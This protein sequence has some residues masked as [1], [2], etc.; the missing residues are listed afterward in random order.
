MSLSLLTG[1]NMSSINYTRLKTNLSL[2]I[3]RLKLLEKKKSEAAQRCRKEIADY[4]ENGKVERAKIRVEQI[5]R[6]DYLVEAMEIVEMFCDLLLARFGMIQQMNT[7][8][9]GLEEAVSS[10]VWVAPRMS[11]DVKELKVIGDLLTQKY[12]KPFAQACK[13]N[14]YKSVNEKL[15]LKLGVQAPPKILVEKYL[16]EIAKMMGVAY[17]PDE[18]ILSDDIKYGGD[19]D[20]NKGSSG[21]GGGSSG[22]GAGQPSKDPGMLPGL[23]IDFK[24]PNAVPSKE[25]P[26][27]PSNVPQGPGMSPGQSDEDYLSKHLRGNR[28]PEIGFIG[29]PPQPGA[30][31]VPPSYESIANRPEVPS[32][33]P[34]VPVEPPETSTGHYPDINLDNLPSVPNLPDIPNDDLTSQSTVPKSGGN[35]SNNDGP[36]QDDVDFD[37]LRRRFESLKNRK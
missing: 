10:L 6:E 20:N 37:D 5:I 28:P 24:D 29:L 34:D 31:S 9:D 11:T 18:E 1:K 17:E 35:P 13:D 36:N 15:M 19:D 12:G 4:L 14:K 26:R 16:I 7:L 30:E 32:V 25:Q 22:G 21:G 8:D 33:V 3:Q 23:L 2:S 27:L